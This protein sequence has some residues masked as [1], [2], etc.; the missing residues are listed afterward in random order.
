ML[1]AKSDASSIESAFSAGANDYITKPF[2]IESIATRTHI[3]ER[4][5]RETCKVFTRD[6]LSDC[7]PGPFG[8]HDFDFA[9]PI[10]FNDLNHHTDPF[11]LGNY[12]SQLAQQRV[13]ETSVF[14]LKIDTFDLLYDELTGRDLLLIIAAVSNSI[15][16][17]TADNRLLNAYVG[18]GIFLCI[19]PDDLVDAWVEVEENISAILKELSPIRKAELL[20]TFSVT[21][22]R[23]VRPYLSKTQRVRRTFD[24]AKVQLSRRLNANMVAN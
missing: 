21:M 2:D 16:T 4:M 5:M 13:T 7:L 12:L 20:D 17:A 11:S 1:T 24:R 22:G 19:A 14:A 8:Q 15:S 6:S 10:V 3:A 18:S 23:P 9:E